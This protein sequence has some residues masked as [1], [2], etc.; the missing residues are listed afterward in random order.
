MAREMGKS[1][2]RYGSGGSGRSMPDQSGSSSSISISG[3]PEL[4]RYDKRT[5]ELGEG[6]SGKGSGKGGG[7][8]SIRGG[9]GKGSGNSS[10]RGDSGKGG[11]N[12]GG[13]DTSA[14]RVFDYIS[15]V[16]VFLIIAVL[17]LIGSFVNKGFLTGANFLN[18]IQACAFLGILSAGMSFITYSGKIVDMS[19]PIT[20]AISGIVAVD[21]LTLGLPTALFLGMLSAVAIG[22]LNGF[23]VGKFGANPII[24]TLSVN[25]LLDGAIRWIYSTSL[26]Y[27]DTVSAANPE[28]A[29]RF[30]NIS[31]VFILGAPLP[32]II[33][34]VMMIAAQLILTKSTIGV[35]LKVI[36]TNPDVAR[37]SG[38]NVTGG[39]MTA[40]LLSSVAA[41]VTG[42][43]ISSFSK[44]GAYYNGVGYDFKAVTAIVLGGMTLAGGRGSMIG[45]MGGVFTISLLSNVLTFLGIGTFVQNIINGALFIVIV[46][47]NTQSLRKTG[48]DDA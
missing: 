21:M 24:W 5:T 43:L 48:K 28:I 32:V 17:I 8:S 19:A 26:I 41:G 14:S 34:V 16:G 6:D 10:I 39:V 29:E 38:I 22:L 27:P 30:I 40:Y 25:Y 23:V 36:G 7:N 3:E 9:S 1:G 47:F 13:S 42:I 35:Q 18:I 44:V 33:M 31:R 11:G 2:D 46:Y 12:S 15:K 4:N 37:F 45:V 20:I